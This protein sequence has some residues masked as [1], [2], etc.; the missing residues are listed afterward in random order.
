MQSPASATTGPGSQTQDAPIPTKRPWGVVT[1]LT[2]N[3]RQV[4]MRL[5]IEAGDLGFVLVD[6]NMY[7]SELKMSIL[8]K[9]IG[10]T[11]GNLTQSVAV[12]LPC[13]PWKIAWEIFPASLRTLR[14]EASN[15]ATWNADTMDE[16]QLLFGDILETPTSSGLTRSLK[17]LS[18]KFCRR[19]VIVISPSAVTHISH[20]AGTKSINVNLIYALVTD[21]G[22]ICWPKDSQGKEMSVSAEL[23]NSIRAKVKADV[24]KIIEKSCQPMSD[25][26]YSFVGMTAPDRSPKKKSS[27]RL[28]RGVG[29]FWRCA[30]R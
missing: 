27:T 16:C 23:E 10:R 22:N 13:F 15:S 7:M 26:W 29:D 6:K 28:L 21:D 20:P 9:L 2:A 18:E 1:P 14:W 19:V 24:K 4:Q 25:A 12:T 5:D 17:T 8:P 3:E 11:M 30:H